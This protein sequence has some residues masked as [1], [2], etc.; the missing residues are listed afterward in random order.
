MAHLEG[1][2]TVLVARTRQLAD[3]LAQ[4][5]QADDEDLIHYVDGAWDISA[6]RKDA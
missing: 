5:L 3:D 2:E 6:L 1:D 4:L